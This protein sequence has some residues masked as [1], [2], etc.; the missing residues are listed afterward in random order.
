MSVETNAALLSALVESGLEYEVLGHARFDEP[1]VAVEAGG[2]REPGVV[3]V[4]G[5]HATE[6][7]GVAAAVALS[8]T[9]ETDR[10]VTIIP[11]RDP[12]GLNGYRWALHRVLGREV[13]LNS[14]AGLADLLKS[15]GEAVYAADEMVLGLL[16]D[17][18]FATVPPGQD[19]ESSQFHLLKRLKT[20]QHRVPD[21][22]EP[23]RGRRILLPPGQPAVPSNGDFE[24]AYSMVVSPD[25]E[26]LHFNRYF[27]RAWAPVETRTVRSVINAVDPGVVFDL[28]E[29]QVADERVFATLNEQGTD[30]GD[31]AQMTVARATI[32][33]AM[34]AGAETATDDDIAAMATI[35]KSDPDADDEAEL[36]ERVADGIYRKPDPSRRNEGQNLTDYATSQGR[37]AMTLETGMLA[38]EARRADRHVAAVRAGIDAF[39]DLDRS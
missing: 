33:G 21:V 22:L 5:A 19:G 37:I 29:T 38:P 16:D 15:R 10:R 12:V 18:G 32:D 35:T 30:G 24:R 13:A 6:H 39:S 9:L 11:T 14:F 27:D 1:I 34:G 23:Y 26:A 3:I 17:V 31:A 4:A 8:Q 7:A 20:L 28:H 25:G 2:T 36:Y